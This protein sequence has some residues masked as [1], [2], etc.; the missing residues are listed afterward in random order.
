MSIFLKLGFLAMFV[1]V[2]GAFITFAFGIYGHDVYPIFCLLC[3]CEL[4]AILIIAYLEFKD[5]NS[6]TRYRRAP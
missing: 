1:T 3:L 5:F 4:F 6:E 2:L